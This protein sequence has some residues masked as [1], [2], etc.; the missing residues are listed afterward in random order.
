M[1][2]V[3]RVL[4]AVAGRMDGLVPKV[5]RRLNEGLHDRQVSIG[6]RRDLSE[7]FT[8]PPARIPVALRPFTVND[9]PAL[10]PLTDAE[11]GAR[12]RADIAWRLGMVERGAF[13]SH[14]FVAVD[15]RSDTPCHVQWLTEAGYDEVI[16]RAGALPTLGG[17]EAMLE[18]AYTPSAYWGLGIMSAVTALLAERAAALGARRVV[19]L[20]DEDNLPSL[21]GARRAGFR[22]YMVRVREQYCYGLFR[23]VRF[24]PMPAA[25]PSEG[26][27]QQAGP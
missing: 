15:E 4:E 9:L 27:S 3:D 19:A 21:K 20:I 5:M 6:M 7:P 14:C 18:N 23:S 8:P 25:A 10:F 22:P 17:D 16:R 26:P 11:V 24:M 2:P 12:E 13:A 1:V